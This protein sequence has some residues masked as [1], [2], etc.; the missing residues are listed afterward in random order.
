MPEGRRDEAICSVACSD[1]VVALAAV[2]VGVSRLIHCVL[3]ASL[4][5]CSLDEGIGLRLVEGEEHG[6]SIAANDE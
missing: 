6:E 4:K 5:A 2:T 3:Y 1:V